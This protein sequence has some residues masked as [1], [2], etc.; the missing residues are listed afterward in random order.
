MGHSGDGAAGRENTVLRM[1]PVEE[2]RGYA[3]CSDRLC[4]CCDVMLPSSMGYHQQHHDSFFLARTWILQFRWQIVMFFRFNLLTDLIGGGPP[5]SALN[6]Y[7]ITGLLFMMGWLSVRDDMRNRDLSQRL[8]AQRLLRL[9][10]WTSV[11]IEISIIG[12]LLF[13]YFADRSEYTG[14]PA[15]L[16]SAALTELVR[17]CMDLI[18]EVY[19]LCVW[20][21]KKH[22]G[23]M[24][25]KPPGLIDK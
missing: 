14:N 4:L 2:T 11:L 23:V 12:L 5:Y 10:T 24:T 17:L 1:E 22:H 16:I 20:S 18:L 21:I 8:W 6:C 19:F 7:I 15:N 9:T 25:A 13:L 3:A